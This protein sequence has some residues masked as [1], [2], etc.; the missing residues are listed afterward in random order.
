MASGTILSYQ[1]TEHLI[2]LFPDDALESIKIVPQWADRGDRL[3]L[4]DSW[5]KDGREREI[6]ILRLEQRQVINNA[7]A[8]AAGATAIRC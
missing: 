3:V 1:I 7:K 2:G 4:K 6:P 5:C 8:L